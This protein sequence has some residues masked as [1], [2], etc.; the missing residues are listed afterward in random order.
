MVQNSKERYLFIF[1]N[2]IQVP[3]AE[4]EALILTHPGVKDCGVIG[5]PDERAGEI[6]L[7]YVVKQHGAQVE[8]QDIIDY[9]AG[10]HSVF[11]IFF[12]C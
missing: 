12:I 8:K 4:V 10:T 6:P 9:V 11:I 3:P 2:D 5:I 7:A 1:E